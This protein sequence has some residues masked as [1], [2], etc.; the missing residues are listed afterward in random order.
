M[1]L[2]VVGATH[3]DETAILTNALHPGASNPV[4]WQRSIGGVAVNVYRSACNHLGSENTAILI[5]SVGSD[6]AATH[7]RESLPD[8]TLTTSEG[9]TDR[10]SAILDRDRHL[11]LGLADTRTIE[12]LDYDVLAPTLD[13]LTAEDMLV[14]DANLS[15]STLTAVLTQI[16][17]PTVAV[18]GVSPVKVM[19]IA[20]H[21]QH[22]GVLFLNRQEACH[23]SG[24]A[25]H[26]P[27][28]A[29][30]AVVSST[31]A[32]QGFSRHVLTDAN[33]PIHISDNGTGSVIEIPALPAGTRIRSV[34]GAGDALAGATV[35]ALMSGLTL[36]ECVS[37][38]GVN[39]ASDVL[40]GK[41]TPLPA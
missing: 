34:N 1:T 40:C 37:G 24:V 20:D 8:A 2:C 18:M 28:E 29:D 3:I 36:H 14:L 13:S 30:L 39:A 16:D 32:E 6:S 5:G 17:A 35:A 26:N 25:R 9:P 4:A 27:D 38:P 11:I 15:V 22:I 31:L 19:R 7:I 41:H 10:Y 33:Q 21:A 12:T 23:L